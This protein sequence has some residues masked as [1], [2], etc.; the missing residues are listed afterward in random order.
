M[1]PLVSAVSGPAGM[2]LPLLDTP[3]MRDQV[4]QAL[5]TAA[6]RL[7]QLSA[8]VGADGFVDEII[9]VV[10]KRTNAESFQRLESIAQLGE[11]IRAAA[12]KSTNVE[13]V[14]QRTKLGGNGPIM[15]NALSS[16]GLQLTYLGALGYPALH[17]VFA[18]FAQRAEVHSIAEPGHT[19]ALEF[20]DGKIMITK[21][22]QLNEVTWANIQT[23]YG[24][25]AFIEKFNQADL[26]AFVNWTMVPF[27]SDLW[28]AL[29]REVCPR[30][31]G[32]RRLAFFDLADPEKRSRADIQRALE[33]MVQFE[34]YFDVILGLNEKEA[35]EIGA[36]LGLATPDRSP[37]G[38]AELAAG[39]Q[40]RQPLGTLVIHPVAY[41]LAAS[42]GDIFRVQ[43][44]FCA[45]PR[46][47]TGAGDHFNAGFC[48][49]RLLG[50]DPPSSLLTGVS[51]S[52]YYVRNGQSPSLSQLAGLQ[53]HW[54]AD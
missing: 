25:A 53:R 54:P 26:V 33:Q 30:M 7:P 49:G 9:H 6:P 1:A 38:L 42:N 19:D 22:V 5:L 23:R 17:P 20:E 44:P 31:T 15:A 27:M 29:L 32:P 48:L 52:G 16:L 40:A 46:I 10:D 3:A 41:A 51:A 11:R 37:A 35:C 2:N 4:A 18:D 43:G 24:R 34:R 47:S 12:G 39:I 28:D 45:K 14:T 36:V 50:L 8:F 21:T 13:L